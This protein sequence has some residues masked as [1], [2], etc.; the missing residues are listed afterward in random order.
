M[1]RESRDSLFPVL[2]HCLGRKTTPFLMSLFINVDKTEW[3]AFAEKV[4]CHQTDRAVH[5]VA[6]LALV[7]VPA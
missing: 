2:V 7:A 5:G 6:W 1:Y 3:C 4:P